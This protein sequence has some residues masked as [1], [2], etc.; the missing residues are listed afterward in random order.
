MCCEVP[1]HILLTWYTTLP[2]AQ[3]L[4][5]GSEI[6]CSAPRTVLPTTPSC[7]ANDVL[8]QISPLPLW[9]LQVLD[10]DTCL[11]WSAHSNPA[12]LIMANTVHEQE[13]LIDLPPGN[14]K[15]Q[16]ESPL[17]PVRGNPQHSYLTPISDRPVPWCL[18]DGRW[19]ASS[20]S[21]FWRGTV[22]QNQQYLPFG[23]LSILIS[24]QVFRPPLNPNGLVQTTPQQQCQ[25]FRLPLLKYYNW[26]ASN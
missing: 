10:D 21:L 8:F 3:P 9:C 6:Y 20:K 13:Y 17:L 18:K 12:K 25:Q 19:A 7:T 22:Y 23:C 5:P 16:K 4:L 11:S 14:I 2:D 26:K 15:Q 1:I 24:Q